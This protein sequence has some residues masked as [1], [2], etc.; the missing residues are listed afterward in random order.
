M[1]N[2]SYLNMAYD[3]SKQSNC[4]RRQVGAVIVT[5]SGL[6]L[7]AANGAPSDVINCLLRGECI[8]Q[9]LNIESGTRHE[10]CNAIHAEQRVIIKALRQCVNLSGATLYVTHKPCAM[11]AK[12]CIEVGIRTIYYSEDYPDEL[13]D[14]ILQLCDINLQKV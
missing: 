9:S 14:N 6:S 12:L 2:Q 11:C 5:E 3:V 10:T 1:Y 8:R 4:I 7:Q 13:S